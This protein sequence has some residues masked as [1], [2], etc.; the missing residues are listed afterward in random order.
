[1]CRQG[2]TIAPK[3]AR[4]SLTPADGKRMV[5]TC[6]PRTRA[7][8][9]C[10]SPGCRQSRGI[11]HA[12]LPPRAHR[13][14]GA[15]SVA[16]DQMRRPKVVA[17]DLD[18]T[19]WE[20][21]LYMM[22][23]HTTLKPLRHASGECFAVRDAWNQELAF[24]QDAQEVIREVSEWEG[25]RLAYVSRTTE[26]EAA[27]LAIESLHVEFDGRT[28]QGVTMADV[29]DHHEIYPGSKIGHFKSLREALDVDYT[30]ILFFD[31]ESYNTREVSGLGVCCVCCPNGL[32]LRAFREGLELYQA[33]HD[34]L[35]KGGSKRDAK[36]MAHVT[37][38]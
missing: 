7:R 32:T 31:N 1:M 4:N 30:E 19:C 14:S 12:G 36:K 16:L 20:P 18:A 10:I 9:A 13:V 17:L 21:E 15:G 6:T 11:K 25:T 8:R 34:F 26:I 28:K 2:S 29:V 23:D 33:M 5:G 22:T 27:H 35:E 3:R 38:R 37:I 24:M